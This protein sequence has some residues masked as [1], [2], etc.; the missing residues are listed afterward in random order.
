VSDSARV[1]ATAG[2]VVVAILGAAA[3]DWSVT[4]VA[5]AAIAAAG[6]GAWITGGSRR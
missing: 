2:F 1:F 5:L 4:G 3:A 6:V